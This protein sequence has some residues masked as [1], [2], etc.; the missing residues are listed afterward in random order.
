MHA[1]VAGAPAATAASITPGRVQATGKLFLG[2]DTPGY[3]PCSATVRTAGER[4]VTAPAL[5]LRPAER[6][7][8]LSDRRLEN[9]LT[10]LVLLAWLTVTMGERPPGAPLLCSCSYG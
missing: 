4:S 2:I 1:A 7:A 6:S 10:A 8:T 3:Q 5:E 9:F